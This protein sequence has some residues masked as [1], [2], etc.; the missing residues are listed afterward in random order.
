MPYPIQKR[1]AGGNH[2]AGKNYALRFG[3]V[4]HIYA[5]NCKRFSGF[6]GYFFGQFITGG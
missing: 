4:Q 1:F 2:S 3:D 5:D 6:V